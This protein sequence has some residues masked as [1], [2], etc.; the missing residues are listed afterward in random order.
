[1]VLAVLV[2]CAGLSYW[3][4]PTVTQPE[5]SQPIATTITPPALTNDRPET[6]PLDGGPYKNVTERGANPL[7]ATSKDVAKDDTRTEDLLASA[8]RELAGGDMVLA[9]AHF[10][11]A[12]NA[13]LSAADTVEARAELR[14]LG[15][16]TIFS[17]SAKP[18]DPLTEYYTI[19]PGDSLYK[20][21]KRYDITA[22]LL[23]RINGIKNLNLIQAGRRVKVVKG[24]FHVRVNK[25]THT[26]DV[27]IN[28]TFVDHYSV[29]LGSDDSTPPG[30]WVVKDKL[31]NPTYYPPRG[32]K[33]VSADDPENPLG[34]RWIGLQGV[35]GDAIG[36]MRI[37]IHGTIEPESIGQNASMGCVRM[38]NEDVEM[39]FDLLVEQKSTVEIVQ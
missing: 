37:G 33:I 4:W 39:V 34:E 35:S 14:K 11:E 36:Q 17:P 26:L 7:S 16:E 9:R 32:G 3:Q 6:A 24:P 8:R 1:M 20:I 29:G 27:F 22:E 10:S 12:L 25:N 2:G 30:G 5:K 28:D 38:L 23:A 19:V 21:A 13:G 15:R 31:K 18:G